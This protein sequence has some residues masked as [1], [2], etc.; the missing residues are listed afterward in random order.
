MQEKLSVDGHFEAL[1]EQL[2]HLR[3]QHQ[4]EQPLIVELQQDNS[5]MEE[6]IRRL[7]SEQVALKAKIHDLKQQRTALSDRRD[8]DQF[9]LLNLRAE[10]NRLQAGVVQSPERVRREI[11]DMSA[12]LESDRELLVEMDARLTSLRA[13]VANEPASCPSRIFTTACSHQFMK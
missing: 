7:N 11:G 12:N 5:R 13:K 9:A 3:A 10:A 2:H 8:R 4:Q 1:T 6:E